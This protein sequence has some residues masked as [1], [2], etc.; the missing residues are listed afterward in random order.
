M[1]FLFLFNSKN[2][3]YVCATVHMGGQGTAS[4][5]SALSFHME[6]EPTKVVRLGGRNLYSLSHIT[7][8]FVCVSRDVLL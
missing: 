2:Y 3:I 4:V 8:P 5:T 6:L 1:N 7:N